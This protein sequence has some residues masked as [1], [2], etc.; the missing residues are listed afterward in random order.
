MILIGDNQS[1]GTETCQCHF[2]QYKSHI[3]KRGKR[4][5][6]NGLGNSTDFKP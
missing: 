4:T 3:E 1:T 5:A 2:V 6:T